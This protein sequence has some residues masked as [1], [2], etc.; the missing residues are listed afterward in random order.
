MKSLFVC[1]AVSVVALIA[2]ACG[3][4]TS[5]KKT[6]GGM[7]Y[8]I[9]R[10][11]DTQ[12]VKVGDYIKLWVTQK[13]N[14]SVV[15]SVNKGVPLYIFVSNQGT[16]PYDVSEIWTSL[17]NGDSLETV[18]M[19]DTFIKRSPQN[20]PPQYKKGDRIITMIKVLGIFSND[21]LGR[22]DEEKMRKE[23]LAGEV[24]EIEK[25]LADNKITAQKT[26]SGAFVQI[27]KPGTGNLIDSGKF[28]TI[29]YTGTSWSGKRFDSNTDTSFHHA[30]PYTF[31]AGALQMIKGFDEAILLLNK[32]AVA[33]FYIPSVIGYGP[34]TDRP[35]IK[36]N[37][38]LKF[39]VEIL[40]VSDKMPEAPQQK[41]VDA[42]Q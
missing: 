6:P 26:R 10:S 17:H 19:M 32:G 40:D 9:Y 25:Y 1:F 2:F 12:Q 22:L 35:G 34:S 3:S 29:N 11:K 38:H 30:Q 16:K 27:L 28:V 24:R 31:Q 20:I 36:A 5:F 14:D 7:P 23:F 21:S 8:K 18:Q 4:K 13:V 15:L 42:P 33:K 41:K 37:E 39:D